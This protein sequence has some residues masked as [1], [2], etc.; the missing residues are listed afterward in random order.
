MIKCFNN[1]SQTREILNCSSSPDIT[2]AIVHRYSNDLIVWFVHERGDFKDY[3]ERMRS[4]PMKG[5][6]WGSTLQGIRGSKISPNKSRSL[7][8]NIFVTNEEHTLMHPALVP[9]W[10]I[11]GKQ[12]KNILGPTTVAI[13][14]LFALMKHHQHP[15]KRQRVNSTNSSHHIL[16]HLTDWNAPWVVDLKCLIGITLVP[17]PTTIS[18]T[19]NLNTFELD[20]FAPNLLN[21]IGPNCLAYNTTAV[22]L[23]VTSSLLP[24]TNT[25]LGRSVREILFT[26]SWGTTR[27]FI[28]LFLFNSY[29]E[30]QTT[31]L[32]GIEIAAYV[33]D[34]ELL[35]KLS[36]D[37][38][39]STVHQLD[40]WSSRISIYRDMVAS[41]FRSPSNQRSLVLSKSTIILYP[42]N[43]IWFHSHLATT[44]SGNGDIS[45]EIWSHNVCFWLCSAVLNRGKHASTAEATIR[46]WTELLADR[47]LHLA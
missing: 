25:A 20:G 36:P 19:K 44:H 17:P 43:I 21:H 23:C 39:T 34:C 29:M 41:R 40:S 2:L 22:N 35:L 45:R 28:L 13:I 32:N 24:Y 31:P 5:T 27:M 4:L 46:S 11:S 42:E 6:N 37:K 15:T 33:N 14:P 9:T 8:I 1:Y 7:L 30:N 47:I 12:S 3:V 18:S 10:K 16:R 26:S 38:W